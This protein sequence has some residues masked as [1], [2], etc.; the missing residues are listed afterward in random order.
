MAAGRPPLFATGIGGN[1]PQRDLKG[2]CEVAAPVDE[3]SAAVL[4]N[5]E[6]LAQRPPSVAQLLR[7]TS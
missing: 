5:A 1:A 2:L 4:L 7:R 6:L 3:P